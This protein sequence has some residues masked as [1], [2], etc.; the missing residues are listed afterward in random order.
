LL[1]NWKGASANIIAEV[2]L[3]SERQPWEY[4]RPNEEGMG[5]VEAK[6]DMG[7]RSRRTLHSNNTSLFGGGTWRGVGG[8]LWYK[9]SRK[10]RKGQS[11]RGNYHKAAAR[12]GIS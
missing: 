8:N 6:V 4:P 5:S 3:S 7:G 12:G 2:T 9:G 11:K 10:K 1:T